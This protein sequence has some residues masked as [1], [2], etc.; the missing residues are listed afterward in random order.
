MFQKE[1][2]K[3]PLVSEPM[4]ANR[5]LLEA[6]SLDDPLSF[7]ARTQVQRKGNI[8]DDIITRIT[9]DYAY[10]GL[11]D[12]DNVV[13]LL[14]DPEIS[15]E[16]KARAVEQA[17]N[18]LNLKQLDARS[19][20]TY[21]SYAASKGR[22]ALE[23]RDRL[24][25]EFTVDDLLAVQQR[26]MRRQ[27][28]KMR[29]EV[30]DLVATKSFN[31]YGEMFVEV[32]QQD[33]IPIYNVASRVGLNQELLEAAG[34]KPVEGWRGLFTGE[35]RQ[36]I[37]DHLVSLPPEEAHFAVQAMTQEVRN[38]EQDP[39]LGPLLTKYN[40]LESFEAIFTEDLLEGG[41]SKNSL[42]RI[43]ANTEVALEAL[44]SAALVRG[45]G[46]GV[47]AIF[48][49]PTSVAARRIADSVDATRARKLDE[50]FGDDELAAKFGLE[51]DQAVPSALPRPALLQDELEALPEGSKRVL[52]RSERVRTEILE[53]TKGLE[54][55]GLTDLEKRAAIRSQLE[56]MDMADGPVVQTRMS[57]VRMMEDESGFVV[58]AVHGKSAEGGYPHLREA[59]D[60]LIEIDPDFKNFDIVR[61][62]DEGIIG[63]V[64][65]DRD[66]LLTSVF[67]K[68]QPPEAVVSPIAG[69]RNEYYLRRRVERPFHIADAQA[70]G[71]KNVLGG[72][73]TRWLLPP[74]QKFSDRIYGNFLKAYRVEQ[75]LIKNFEVMFKPF[76]DLPVADKQVVTKLYDWTEQFGKEHGRAPTL[77]DIFAKHG[78]LTTNQING[79]I[80]LRSGMDT[81]HELFNRR[82]YQEFKSLDYKTARPANPQMATY[83]GISVPKESAPVGGYFDPV[84]EEMV[85]L[86]RKELD[87][88][89][90]T[91]GG[92]MQLD[93]AL[94]TPG[95]ARSQYDRVVFRGGSDQVYEVGELSTKPLKYHPGY[96][97]RF[98]E[99]P[100]FIVKRTAGVTKNGAA[101]SS[102]NAVTQ[103]AIR[104]AGTKAEAERFLSRLPTNE[105]GVEWDII[106]ARNLSV[107]EN[108]LF[109]KQTIHREG[110]LFWDERNFDRIPDTSG[111]AARLEDPVQS[112]ERGVALAAR[113]LTHEDLTKT[114]KEAFLKE[115][116]DLVDEVRFRNKSLTEV[117][118][119][120]TTLRQNTVEAAK[121]KR[122]AD[123]I[124]LVD[125]F[126][127]MSGTESSLVPALR[128]A[129]MSVAHTLGRG[130]TADRGFRY[131][132]SRG[133][134]KYIQGMD[135]FRTMRTIAFNAFMVFRPVRQA[136]LQSAQIG[137]LSGIDPAY[138]A[139]TKLFTDRYALGM[140]LMRARRS[141]YDDGYSVAKLAKMMGL[142]Q[143]EYRKLV[144]M[145]D[146]SGLVDTVDVHS[147]AG[148]ARRFTKVKLPE[149][150]TGHI[151]YRAKQIPVGIREAFQRFGFDFGE[152]NNITFTYNLALRRYLKR[153]KKASLL[154]LDDKAWD[155]IAND[156]S[157]LALGMLRPNQFGYQTGA[158]SVP[159]Q[160]LSFTHKAMLAMLGQNPALKGA[161][162]AKLWAGTMVLY[163][164]NMFGARDYVE[165]K[166]TEMGIADKPIAGMEGETLVD[167]I[168][169]G[170]VDTVFNE[171]MDSL[172]ADWKDLDLRFLAPGIDTVRLWDMQISAIATQPAWKTAFGP[173]GNIF[174]KT[175]TSF[176]VA[177]TYVEGAPDLP[178]E[179]KVVILADAI[180]RGVLPQYND[181]VMSYI[182]YQTNQWYSA[183][184]EALPIRTT[185]NTLIA[186][187]AF[188]GRSREELAYY[189]LQ[190]EKW[191]SESFYREIVDK[192][193][194]AIRAWIVR[195]QGGTLTTKELKENLRALSV[196]MEE[197][198][199]HQ[200]AKIIEASL[201]EDFNDG[202]PPI[203]T[204]IVEAAKTLDFKPDW[205][206]I[207]DNDPSLTDDQRLELKTWLRD[208]Y[209]R[210]VETNKQL[211]D[212][213]LEEVESNGRTR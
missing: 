115:Y 207:I 12:D 96:S 191:E 90:N 48:D 7:E 76:Y 134:E 135:P 137:F 22:I 203:S 205:L 190:N 57:T 162:V 209:E 213:V 210:Q 89:Y 120:L 112:L 103:E 193:K 67:K 194:D 82:L 79:V 145:F 122:I 16:D 74:N 28:G 212:R 200:K 8:V 30:D 186:R 71:S 160:F 62:N 152:R 109:Q 185:M 182:G 174:S 14:R 58:D 211:G 141:G 171:L 154:E 184:N 151:G 100:Y 54:T 78:E 61:V 183:S 40:V 83:H 117:K 192:N 125:Y 118:K 50:L 108:T 38:L 63:P 13:A 49:A 173:F 25:N 85:T 157:N 3:T 75:G 202:A 77:S 198:P 91:G 29:R 53:T 140:G 18:R 116:A 52:E 128:E 150:K 204:Q 136:L 10:Q 165:A 102:A 169:G 126:R 80:A 37:R 147:F 98:Y 44:F 19:H 170:L 121:K 178:P 11:R 130:S 148:G 199:E 17:A 138:V 175:L 189:R 64:F 172:V 208:V 66:E 59:I 101:Q 143:K 55:L 129:A 206:S 88:I 164:S 81:M 46:R 43:L 36:A 159:T 201:L 163:G 124:E 187:G 113:Q 33:F 23:Q 45:I 142:S 65:K 24:F 105:E 15:P 69:L 27:W 1:T 107:T 47:A 106:P 149:T 180:A 92:V 181:L 99:D 104:T 31:S 41:D 111:A 94:P 42:D 188:G 177:Q 34:G 168:S 179:E 196:W 72:T 97:L 60:E 32:A 156:A 56:A 4:A 39:H 127:L 144:K 176:D 139:S 70:L 166:L 35:V 119:D 86:T 161:D 5:A 73:L 167:M 114:I 146:R 68:Q 51:A 123:A 95:Q 131:K 84:A 110:R 6:D 9:Q 132:F 93:T 158:L 153:N 26:D 20:F 2:P 197:F 21:L 87:D 195:W 155:A 133:A